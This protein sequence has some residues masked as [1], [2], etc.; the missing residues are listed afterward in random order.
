[1]NDA[2]I[3]KSSTCVSLPEK[4]FSCDSLDT[5]AQLGT[6]DHF[7]RSGDDDFDVVSATEKSDKKSLKKRARRKYL[8]SGY[9][10]ALVDAAKTNDASSLTKSYW[11]TY[12]CAKTLVLTS[13]GK[14]SGKYCKNRWCLVCNSIRTAQLINKY[15]PVLDSWD[16]QYFV[17]LTTPNVEACDLREAINVMQGIFVKAKERLK[18]RAQR[19]KGEKFK[20][21]RKLE[22][23]YNPLRND[24]HP[25]FHLII[26]GKTN[27]TSLLDDWLKGYND[28]FHSTIWGN[29]DMKAQDIKKVDAG[30]A[31]ELF[32]YFTKVISG[33]GKEDRMIYADAMD[34]IFNS[35]KG[36]RVFQPF[37]FTVK[38]EL[39]DKENESDS[40]VITEY[41]WD[42]FKADWQGGGYG[43]RL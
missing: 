21:I 30:G 25:H 1:M 37:G 22:I 20:G 28:S 11:S 42:Q 26:D 5:L 29:A 14:V 35:V 9:I 17:T 13:D 12:H 41:E 36:K 27:A 18:K 8:T 39:K 3:S 33:K 6:N 16:N 38:S 31:M 34:I 40:Y 24:F 7:N 23:T 32:K 43:S 19:G 2:N 10:G 15:Q 4:S